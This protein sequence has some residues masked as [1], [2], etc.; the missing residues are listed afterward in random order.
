MLYEV[1]IYNTKGQPDFREILIPNAK[2]PSKVNSS[3]T[4]KRL[5]KRKI[6]DFKG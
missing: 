3:L 1:R 5:D 2:P 4:L 6:T